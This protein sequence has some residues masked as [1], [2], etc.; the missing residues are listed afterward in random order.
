MA[1]HHGHFW[2]NPVTFSQKT[3]AENYQIKTNKT[4]PQNHIKKPTKTFDL[5]L[6]ISCQK[7]EIL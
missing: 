4:H 7:Q 5:L 6:A 3:S 1:D 2:D